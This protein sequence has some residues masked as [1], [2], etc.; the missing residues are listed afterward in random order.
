MQFRN[1]PWHDDVGLRQNDMA[2]DD[3]AEEDDEDE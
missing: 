2:E 1:H 3:D